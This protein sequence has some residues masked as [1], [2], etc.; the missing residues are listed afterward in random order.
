MVVVYKM[1]ECKIFRAVYIEMANNNVSG[2][3]EESYDFSYLCTLWGDG[4]GVLL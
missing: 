2:Y 3:K 4:G 1:C